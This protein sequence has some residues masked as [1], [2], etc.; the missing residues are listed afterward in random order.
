MNSGLADFL[1]IAIPAIL[2]GAI[3]LA[4]M[5]RRE[6]APA[7]GLRGEQRW[8]LG[9][10]L[11]MGLV[12]FSIKLGVA[13]ILSNA[14]GATVDALAARDFGSAVMPDDDS[15][16]SIKAF[17]NPASGNGQRYVWERL[18]QEAPAPAG[19]PTTAAR[20]TLGERLFNER[21]L[22]GDGTLN[23]ASCHDLTGHAGA[24]G[25]PLARGIADQVGPRNTP[26]VW[27]AAFQSVLFWDGRAPSLEAQAGGP[28]LNPVEMGLASAEEAERRLGS[29]ADYRRLF[30]AAFGDAAVTFPRIVQA[31][32]AYE[33]TLITP[34]SPYDRFVDGDAGALSP[35]QLRGMALFEKLGCIL[36]HRGPNFSDAS[37][38]G[39]QS[40]LRYFP[41]NPTPYEKRYPL[42]GADGRPGVW[43]VP[44]LR[45]V[46]L[47]GPWL[48]NGSVDRLDEVVRIMASAQLGRS[49]SLQAWIDG[50]SALH[51]ADQTP[52]PDAQVA[53]LVAFLE[54]LSSDRLRR[55]AGLP[56]DTRAE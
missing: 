9:L 13:L 33:R 49:R 30:A 32:A 28:I 10:A 24:D 19:L 7:V 52:L 1:M 5:V 56:A 40:A 31:L 55:Q 14:P 18:P 38:L 45:N 46:A 8:L 15:V 44:S 22:S 42:L 16:A 29:D 36:C 20:V 34:D 3:V 6:L 39:G 27:N 51:L 47:T 26:T 17:I 12:A 35:A 4:L 50:E 11:G 37:L 25:R 43:R 54:A 53:D 41:A 23:C 21:R 2:T 48:H